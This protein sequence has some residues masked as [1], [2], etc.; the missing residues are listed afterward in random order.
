MGLPGRSWNHTGPGN[1]EAPKE[2]QVLP[3]IMLKAETEGRILC[4][5]PSSYSPFFCQGPLIANPGQKPG[6][7][8]L[9]GSVLHY[10]QSNRKARSES[11]AKQAKDW[12]KC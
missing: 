11:E 9:P 12:H 7:Y 4:F 2:T 8:S 1:T 6:N 5:L 10:R 3:E